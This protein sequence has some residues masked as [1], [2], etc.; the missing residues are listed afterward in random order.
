MSAELLPL[1][2]IRH[3]LSRSERAPDRLGPASTWSGAERLWL[4][5]GLYHY[6][7]SLPRTTALMT[8]LTKLTTRAPKKADQKP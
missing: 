8:A 1:I 3:E 4:N 2:G 5:Y 7:S 6:S